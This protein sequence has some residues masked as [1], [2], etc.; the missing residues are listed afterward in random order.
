MSGGVR[1]RFSAKARTAQLFAS[2]TL[3]LKTPPTPI[4]TTFD[5][6]TTP[7]LLAGQPPQG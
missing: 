1:R 4:I 3:I 7:T 5:P 2:A 6:P